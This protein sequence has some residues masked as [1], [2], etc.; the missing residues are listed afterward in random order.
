M[1]DDHA[2]VRMCAIEGCNIRMSSVDKDRHL[3]C[4]GHTG[5]QCSWDQRCEVCRDWTDQD[6][7]NYVRLQEGK[8]QK[9]AHKEKK[10]AAK[11]AAGMSTGS[12]AHSLSPSSL[13]SND[14]GE[15][16]SNVFV[17]VRS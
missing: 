1:A 16:F 13:S 7:R 11:L 3:I 8:A 5:W 12:S 14:L 9:K 15:V 17:A 10:K 4:P 6:M 2:K